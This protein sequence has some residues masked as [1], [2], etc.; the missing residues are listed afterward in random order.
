[1]AGVPS[2]AVIAIRTSRQRVLTPFPLGYG[3]PHCCNRC[4]RVPLKQGK[5]DPRQG[6]QAINPGS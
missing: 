4:A 6:L 2:P 1:M 5:A 3:P